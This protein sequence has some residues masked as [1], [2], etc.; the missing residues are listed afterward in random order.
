MIIL[1]LIPAI[2]SILLNG[3]LLGSVFLFAYTLA[4]VTVLPHT[5][6]LIA[7]WYFI[8]YAIIITFTLLSFTK[9]GD[10]LVRLFKNARLP[11]ADEKT[12]IYSLIEPIATKEKM[13]LHRL[14]ILI[15]DKKDVYIE[16]FGRTIILTRRLLKTC[17][18]DELSAALANKIWHVHEKKSGILSAIAFAG[19]PLYLVIGFYHVYKIILMAISKFGGRYGSLGY[20]IGI[21]LAL[22]LFPIIALYWLGQI[23]LK[24]CLSILLRKYEYQADQFVAQNGLYPHLVSYLEKADLI[25]EANHGIFNLIKSYQPSM[26]QRINAL[27][28]RC[29]VPDQS[30]ANDVAT[31]NTVTSN[32]VT[33]NA[34]TSNA[35]T[36]NLVTDA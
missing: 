5:D 19:A 29:D 32:T 4:Y 16:A 25:S 10:Y 31:H 7:Q 36:R 12:K 30:V 26:Q 35:V 15:S 17:S 1:I 20:A 27:Q 18:D 34:A 14:Q 21:F 22:P 9:I 2:I 23:F 11:T 28:Q 24:F 13:K 8:S 6:K 3:F 33:S